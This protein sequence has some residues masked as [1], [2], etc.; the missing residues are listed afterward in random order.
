MP[1]PSFTIAGTLL[2]LLG[3][4]ALGEIV[5][6]GLGGA[7]PASVT[8]TSN[9]PAGNFVTFDGVAYRVDEVTATVGSD[10]SITRNGDTVLLL[11]NDGGLSVDGVQWQ[12]HVTGMKRFWFNAPTDGGTVNLGSVAP[13]PGVSLVGLTTLDWNSITGKPAVAVA[14]AGD[15][16]ITVSGTVCQATNLHTNVVDY[17]VASG[18]H[19]P[20]F[21]NAI[22]SLLDLGGPTGGTGGKVLYRGQPTFT[23]QLVIACDITL[24]AMPSP[25]WGSNIICQYDGS[26]VVITGTAERNAGA[27]LI[28]VGLIGNHSLTHQ[29][30]IEFNDSGGANAR[31]VILESCFSDLMGQ[32]GIVLNGT[33][34]TAGGKVFMHGAT[35]IENCAGDGI[36]A[37]NDAGST[38]QVVD[39][40]IA[41][42]TGAG[43]RGN[44]SYYVNFAAT[45]FAANAAGAIIL[46]TGTNT[47]SVSGCH[48]D[49]GNGSG[50]TPTISCPQAANGAAQVL[51]NNNTFKGVDGLVNHIVIGTTYLAFATIVGNHFYNTTGPAIRWLPLIDHQLIIR[52]NRGYND[53]FSKIATP[54]KDNG[55]AS[56]YTLSPLGNTATPTASRAYFVNGTDL[57]LAVSGGTGVS[58]TITDADGNTVQAG[59]MSFM[60]V[61]PIGYAINFGAFSVAPTLYAGVI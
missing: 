9:V 29:N 34:A 21:Q 36:N 45:R 25:S 38:L 4:T 39:A 49:T 47:F 31:D 6:N 7:T 43:F 15:Y 11:A 40:Y 27:K 56:S 5:G 58:I 18:D 46:G 51:I 14:A 26:A 19:T 33:T 8:F 30:G 37:V 44:N 57:M 53:A 12:A 1:L 59:L 20:V 50:A 60:G 17:A 10:G 61:L 13:V 22:D 42:N 48:L 16:L 41:G 23:S 55:G 3:N 24:E 35:E 32:H 28:N 52:S 54:V 2:D